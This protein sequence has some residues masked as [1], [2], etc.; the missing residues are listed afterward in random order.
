MRLAYAS[1]FH[2]MPKRHRRNNPQP[3]ESNHQGTPGRV[4]DVCLLSLERC[5]SLL[6]ANCDLSNAEL[7]R[8]RDSIYC[9]AG[10]TIDGFLEGSSKGKHCLFSQRRRNLLHLAG[11]DSAWRGCASHAVTRSTQKHTGN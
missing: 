7:E 3:N 11:P 1:L 9:L 6:P 5:R 2:F 8:L 4:P 10:V